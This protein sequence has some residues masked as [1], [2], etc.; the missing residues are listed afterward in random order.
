M[1]EEERRRLDMRIDPATR[2]RLVA[3]AAKLELPQAAIVRTA[4]REMAERHGVEGQ[5]PPAPPRPAAPE[6]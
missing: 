2:R 1:T 5:P 3:L 4:V 6:E